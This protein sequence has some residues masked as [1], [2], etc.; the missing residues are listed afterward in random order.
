[1]LY[2]I[3]TIV[4]LW[5]GN[6]GSYLPSWVVRASL[7]GVAIA[8][9]KGRLFQSRAANIK[10]PFE[11]PAP[12][13]TTTTRTS[14]RSTSSKTQITGVQSSPPFPISCPLTAV[15]CTPSFVL[16]HPRRPI[17]IS[18][19]RGTWSSCLLLASGLRIAFPP[20]PSTVRN[21]RR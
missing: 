1:M 11:H 12:E 10:P 17:V 8:A 9:R 20:E 16:L 15:P 18:F 7:L 4:L 13:T 6:C 2:L 3:V 14:T 21:L 19:Q 5:E